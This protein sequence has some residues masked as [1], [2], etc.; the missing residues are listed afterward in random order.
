MTAEYVYVAQCGLNGP[1]K[2]GCSA[3]PPKRLAQLQIG[4][5]AE[6][7]IVCCFPGDQEIERMMHRLLE[8]H[9]I[10]GEWFHPQAT[11]DLLRR[12]YVDGVIP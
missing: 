4:N 2:I 6:M 8:E 9:R 1:V 11:E 3:N 5:P 10:A 7:R 12:L